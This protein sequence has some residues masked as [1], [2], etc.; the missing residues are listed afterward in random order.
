[1]FNTE[2]LMGYMLEFLKK[3]LV[4]CEA[5][6][7]ELDFEE[8]REP[9]FFPDG[10]YKKSN[11]L[12][13]PDFTSFIHIT[14]RERLISENE[15]EKV[16]ELLRHLYE[17]KIEE[18]FPNLTE[19]LPLNFLIQY[20]NEKNNL[21]YKLEESFLYEERRFQIIFEKFKLFLHNIEDEDYVTPL[22]NFESDDIDDN[23]VTIDQIVLRK[24][25][26]HEFSKISE[27]DDNPDLPNI[28]LK[29]THVLVYNIKSVDKTPVFDEAERKFRSIIEGLSLIKDGSPKFGEIFRNLNTP[30]ITLERNHKKI[31]AVNNSTLK[32]K[33]SEIQNVGIICKHLKQID[34]QK[35]S[36]KFLKISKTRFV[37]A[38]SRLGEDDQILDLA[39]SLEALFIDGSGGDISYKLKT[40]IATF[41]GENDD[42]RKNLYEI[43]DAAYNFR[44]GIAH[45][46]ERHPC[47]NGKNV[48][49][50]DVVSKVI[51]V[52]R[53]SILNFLKLMNSEQNYTK[54]SIIRKIDESV[55][56]KKTFEEFKEQ[57]K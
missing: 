10:R 34:Y 18:K 21:P 52:N 50:T 17:Q 42:D 16:L 5:E 51:D 41:L 54:T 11:K 47:I 26:P 33:K 35:K 7:N 14:I 29:L 30:W 56:N 12:D 37:S 36:N 49:L 55:I 53:Q 2:T 8:I 38:I 44:S 46:D 9:E 15:F 25:R 23:G 27:L 45:G 28:F 32:I 31:L 20:L 24:I 4:I 43:I 19:R 3:S 22:F 1:M 39:I 57:Y 48:S 13:I 6:K 40:R